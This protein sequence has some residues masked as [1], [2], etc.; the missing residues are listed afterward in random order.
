MKYNYASFFLLPVIFLFT[1]CSEPNNQNNGELVDVAYFV[2]VYE[3]ATSIASRVTVDEPQPYQQSGKVITY[4]DYIFINKPN[5][6]IHVVDNSN[7]EAP[8]NLS[9]ISLKGN[10]DLAI[11]D[12]YL[13]ADMFSALVVLN[14]QDIQNPSVVTDY[15][16]E[17]VF[18]YDRYIFLPPFDTASGYD[19]VRYD[20]VDSSQGIVVDWTIEVRKEVIEIYDYDIGVLESTTAISFDDDFS[21]ENIS[22]AGSMTRFLP[23]ENYLYTLS[24]NE[25]ILFELDSEYRPNRWGKLDTGTQAETLFSLNDLLFVGSVSGMLMYDITDAANP[26][27]IN[28]IDHFRSCDPV[29]ADSTHAYVTLRGGTNCFTQNNELQVIDIQNPEELFVASKHIMFNPHGLAVISDHLIVCD[30]TAG[31]KVVDVSDKSTPEVVNIYPIDFAYDVIV[32][33][34]NALVVG[35]ETMHQYDISNL[36]EMV[37]I[38]ELNVGTAD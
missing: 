19:H 31:I 2:P 36:P 38:S 29:V 27:Y 23:V 18:Y 33:Y 14:I 24:F 37:K 3:S 4:G 1:N 22:T 8:V 20:Y 16:V 10:L 12:D 7:P 13:Y 28:S 9:F 17:D 26:S 34:P 11:V 25:M 21:P 5:E 35:E 30:G 6:G 15:T 32:D